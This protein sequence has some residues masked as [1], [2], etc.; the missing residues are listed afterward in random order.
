MAYC[1]DTVKNVIGSR[2]EQTLKTGFEA[3]LKFIFNV[4]VEISI[5]LRGQLADNVTNI[6]Y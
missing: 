1:V 6:I 3:A 4:H 2:Q 5:Y